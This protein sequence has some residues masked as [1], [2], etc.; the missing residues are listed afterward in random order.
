M[1]RETLP[2]TLVF[3]VGPPAVGKMTV[4][5]A[6]AERTGL[7]LFHN[8]QTIELALN[9]FEFGTPPFGRLV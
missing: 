3:I 4:G 7:R 1:T 9:F 8:H 6:L 5:F 2:P